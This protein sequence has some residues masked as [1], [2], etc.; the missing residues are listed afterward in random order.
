ML[1][2]ETEGSRETEPAAEETAPGAR[3][4][5]PERSLALA[6]TLVPLFLHTLFFSKAGGFWRD[7]A[8][9]L[10]LAAMPDLHSLWSAL[11]FDSFPVLHVL[12]IRGWSAVWGTGDVSLRALGLTVGV[13]IIAALWFNGR[14]FGNRAPLLSLLLLGMSP[15]M[16]RSLDSIRPNGLAAL[17]TILAFTLVW[18]AVEK[19]D[20]VRLSA[21]TLALVLSVQTLFQGAI[22]ILAMGLAAFIVGFLEGGLRRVMRLAVPFLAAALSL[23]PYV[24]NLREV[25]K[26]SPVAMTPAGTKQLLPGLLGALRSP[27]PWFAWVWVAVGICAIVGVFLGLSGKGRGEGGGRGRFERTLYC[28]VTLVVSAA[29]FTL[30]LAREVNF[31]PQAW[32]YVPLLVVAVISAEPLTALALQAKSAR[33]VSRFLV[34]GIALAALLP[35]IQNLKLRMTSMDLIASAIERQAGADD[36][37]IVNPWYYGVSLTRYYH[38]RAPWRTFPSL[39]ET[40]LHRYDLLKERMQ[41]PE[42]I[43][44]DVARISATLQ[45]GGRVWFVG[46]AHEVD[47]GVVVIHLPPAPLPRTGWSS[48][49]YLSNWSHQ[50]MAILQEHPRQADLVPIQSDQLISPFES[51]RLAVFQGWQP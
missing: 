21:A 26:W 35:A 45:R 4:T 40:A 30:F 34:A 33:L 47:P 44:E 38:G 39:P 25:G 3:L 31:S 49:P 27:E 46:D 28:A 36:L 23:V 32:H 8:N 5:L 22:F 41:R 24:D 7:E 2:M 37:V 48:V 12:V 15:A 51:P 1:V 13:A 43:D 18:R 19:P 6:L 50:L 42:T 11:K 9:S 20:A 17:A 10:A 16:V 29:G 14:A